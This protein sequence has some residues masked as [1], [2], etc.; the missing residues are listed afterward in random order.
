MYNIDK[1]NFSKGG[2]SNMSKV[3][4]S[5]DY[6]KLIEEDDGFY[7]ESYKKGYTLEEFNQ[8]LSDFPQI[9]ITNFVVLRNTILNAPKFQTKFAEKRERVEITVTKDHLK[10]FATLYI[11]ASELTEENREKIALEILEALQ[12]KGIV[13]GIIQDALLKEFKPKIRFLIAQ[14]KLPVEGKPSVIK[15]Y[16]IQEPKPK[17]TEDGKVNHYELNLINK[18]ER[19]GWL[20][21]RIDATPGEPGKSV[22]GEEIPA[23]PGK[24]LPL[25]YDRNSVEEVYDKEKGITTLIA[26]KPGAVFYK[27]DVIY[28][29]DY[30]EIEGD[31]SFETGNINFD[32]FVNIKGTIED[33]YSVEAKHDIEVLGSMGIGGINKIYSKDGCIYIRGG[34]AGKNKARIYCKQNLY[35]KF[36][37]DCIIECEGTV[38]IGF[39]AINCYI[40][41]KQVIFESKNSRI[42]GG[43]I[44]AEIKVVANE[45]GNRTEIPTYIHV[46]GFNR[47]K[48]KDTFDQINDSIKEINEDLA[49]LK[50]RAAIYRGSGNLSEKHQYEFKRILK[51]I[52]NL[53]EELKRLQA[54]RKNYLS[55]LR[56][57]G[58]GEI[59]IYG[60]VHGNTTFEIK[61]IQK[62]FMDQ[63]RGPI[64][65]Y[66]LENELKSS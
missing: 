61:N 60:I 36:A 8:I 12:D 65:Y 21:E 46:K 10:A 22:F 49:Q 62:R 19:G 16:E 5:N 13:Y 15:M 18:V 6:I 34:I 59:T 41:A 58:E 51:D 7:I 45:V 2:E 37:S 50:H 43:R 32:G 3:I 25:L 30:L 20:G 23:K 55:Y 33:N 48:F 31:V 66:V 28:V 56:A 35:T 1:E 24:Q 9:R 17:I 26:K 29:Y 40:K 44:D 42:I 27:D 38:H 63:T 64:T 57:K 53:R 52:S 54:E 14:G 47:K 11:P 39:Y 4:F